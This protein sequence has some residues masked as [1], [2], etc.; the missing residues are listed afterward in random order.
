MPSWATPA[1]HA[2]DAGGDCDVILL[3]P[4]GT[5]VR[6]RLTGAY[7]D[8]C[9]RTGGAENPRFAA[10]IRAQLAA[11]VDTLEG[12]MVT[13]AGLWARV[14]GAQWLQVLAREGWPV[15]IRIPVLGLT[16]A[17]L[18]DSADLLD[19]IEVAGR[20]LLH[21]LIDGEYIPISEL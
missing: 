14:E 12:T 16:G 18:F 13:P 1:V 21:E 4:A 17:A 11:G 10:A 2:A 3:P 19:M 20:P 8:A 6:V 15:E 9:E 7:A 5:Q